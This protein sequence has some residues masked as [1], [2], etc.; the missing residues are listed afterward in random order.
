MQI[1]IT[2]SNR[3]FELAYE[4]L[5]KAKVLGC[6]TETG[7]LDPRNAELF[8]VQFSDGDFNVLVPTSEGVSLGKLAEILENDSI[9]KIFHNARFDLG[10]LSANGYKTKNVYDSMIAEKV[11]TKGA[12]QS[13]SLAET[14]YRYY[15]VDLDKA[16]RKKFGKNWD[17]VWTK[18]LVEY[19]M[20]D[21][22]YLPR[23]RNEQLEWLKR[24][25]L[26][27]DFEILLEKTMSAV[28]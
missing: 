25:G 26:E 24:L 6:D 18:E 17:K 7:G 8:S 22:V 16:Q 21:V 5:S 10:F 12:N 9:T 15:A 23:L 13:V 19:A 14:L 2:R 28:K 1:L 27:V 11:L 4:K 20:N 3:D